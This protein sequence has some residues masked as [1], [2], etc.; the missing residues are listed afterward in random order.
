MC[1]GKAVSSRSTPSQCR[2]HLQTRTEGQHWAMLPW[3][4]QFNAPGK[5]QRIR[6]WL[7]SIT[8]P[9][10]RHL[11]RSLVALMGWTGCPRCPSCDPTALLE[12]RGS[13]LTTVWYVYL[14]T[15]WQS[16]YHLDLLSRSW[17]TW[18]APWSWD[19]QMLLRLMTPQQLGC[20][21]L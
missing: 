9:Q 4:V 7:G 14:A 17:C 21:I 12:A 6:M 1:S 20:P 16:S 2:L 11:L 5:C 15:R 13:C 19:V 3:P 8:W 10:D 18:R